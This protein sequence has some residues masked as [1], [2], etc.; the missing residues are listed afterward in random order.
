MPDGGAPQDPLPGYLAGLERGALV[1]LLLEAAAA[2][3]ALAGRLRA[4]AALAELREAGRRARQARPGAEAVL[5]AQQAIEQLWAAEQAADAASPE[6]RSLADEFAQL[7][8]TACAAAASGTAADAAALGAWLARRHLLPSRLPGPGAPRGLTAYTDLLGGSGLAAYATALTRGEQPAPARRLEELHTLR[9]DTDAL[10]AVLATD[11]GHP[12]RHL[13]IAELLAAADRVPEAVGWAERGVAAVAD[14]L[15][16]EDRLTDFLTVHYAAVGRREDALALLRE[17]FL[18]RPD[19]AAY[20]ALLAAAGPDGAG[21]EREWALAELHRRASRTT[22]R[23]WENPAAPLIE[24]LV[25]TGDLDAAWAAADR[26]DVPRPARLRLARLRADT[27]PAD[28][29]PVYRQ[30]VEARIELMTRES[31]RAAVDL[32]LQLRE[33]HEKSGAPDAFDGLLAE[34]RSTHRAKGSLLAELDAHGL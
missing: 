12:S 15:G 1:A 18:A 20:R 29:I 2:D 28:A 19:P 21:E 17:Q 14:G 31:Y 34:L 7:H 26:Y 27:H 24:V 30:E 5:L 22:A 9:G 11:L 4:D 25:A 8:L 6:L 3:G 10:V 23:S 32:V 33:L 16:R 13:R